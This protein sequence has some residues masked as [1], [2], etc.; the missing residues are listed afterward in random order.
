MRSLAASAV[1]AS[2]QP[3]LDQ[4]RSLEPGYIQKDT[5]NQLKTRL[6]PS[7]D[8]I[9]QPGR[10]DDFFL[11]TG[12]QDRPPKKIFT[13]RDTRLVWGLKIDPAAMFAVAT[14]TT[15]FEELFAWV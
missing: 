12:Q 5:D 8:L 1:A 13:L 4:V 14:S 7:C 10:L 15:A 9:E 3:N 6:I 2:R 11:Y